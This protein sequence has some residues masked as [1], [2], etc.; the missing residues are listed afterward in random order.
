MPQCPTC[1]SAVSERD[2]ICPDCGMDLRDEAGTHVE[3]AVLPA[4]PVEPVPQTLAEASLAEDTEAQAPVAPAITDAQVGEEEGVV[5]EATPP[6]GLSLPEPQPTPPATAEPRREA[7]APSARITLRRGGTM[8][9]EVFQLGE[10]AVLGRFDPETGPVDVDLA[11]LPE[12][13][14][15]SRRHAEIWCDITGAWLIKDLGSANGTFVRAAEAPRFERV[16]DEQAVA[17]G[18]EIGLGNARF[19]FHTTQ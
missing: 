1:G 4:P 3:V 12:A 17:D 7:P 16:G 18:Y 6:D 10:R 9:S 5:A 19:E 14:Y 11:Q 8:T 15:V 13:V 2:V